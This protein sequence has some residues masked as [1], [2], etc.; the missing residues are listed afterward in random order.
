MRSTKIKYNEQL[1]RLFRL[2]S[3]EQ[4]W[5]CVSCWGKKHTTFPLFWVENKQFF[6]SATTLHCSFN[7]AKSRKITK[8]LWSLHDIFFPCC[9]PLSFVG[10]YF[11]DFDFW[12]SC[13]STDKCNCCGPKQLAVFFFSVTR[14]S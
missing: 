9:L 5:D 10:S 2:F 11:Y 8:F 7:E 13:F 14:T 12:N 1:F 3:F 6:F 4:L